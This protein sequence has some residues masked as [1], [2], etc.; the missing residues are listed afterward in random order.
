MFRNGL[1]VDAVSE[2]CMVLGVIQLVLV[3]LLRLFLGFQLQSN[4]SD[5]NNSEVS[6]SEVPPLLLLLRHVS[7]HLEAITESFAVTQGTAMKCPHSSPELL[8]FNQSLRAFRRASPHSVICRLCMLGRAVWC[9]DLLYCGQIGG[10]KY[11]V[12]QEKNVCYVDNIYNSTIK[13]EQWQLLS[14]WHIIRHLKGKYLTEYSNCFRV[15]FGISQKICGFQVCFH[16]VRPT[17]HEQ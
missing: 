14:T 12:H 1:N 8:V 7:L 5:M 10:H 17:A 3:W 9:G 4:R 11:Y 15:T 13:V 6:S 16:F 2:W